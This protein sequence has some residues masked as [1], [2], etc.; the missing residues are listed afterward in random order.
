MSFPLREIWSFN[1]SYFLYFLHYYIRLTKGWPAHQYND[2]CKTLK[3]VKVKSM[4][5]IIEVG[6]K[7]TSTFLILR[8]CVRVFS[9]LSKE[10]IKINGSKAKSSLQALQYEEDLLPGKSVFSFHRYEG[11]PIF[12]MILISVELTHR[13]ETFT[14]CDKLNTTTPCCR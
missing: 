12:V 11:N 10:V 5:R 9:G 4:K 8:G 7:G 3:F 2:L 6:S 1:C 14:F 13:A